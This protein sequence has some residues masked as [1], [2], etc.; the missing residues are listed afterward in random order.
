MCDSEG[1]L[2]L[3]D[4]NK[5]LWELQVDYELFALH[6]LDVTGEKILRIF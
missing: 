6:L 4:T 5:S 3:K 1:V 2:K